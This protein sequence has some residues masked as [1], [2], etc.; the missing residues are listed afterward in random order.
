MSAPYTATKATCQQLRKNSIG[1]LLIVLACG[2]TVFRIVA[3]PCLFS[4]S[5]NCMEVAR[6]ELLVHGISCLIQ[7]INGYPLHACFHITGYVES[8]LLGNSTK[9]CCVK[10]TR[11]RVK[12]YGLRGRGVRTLDQLRVLELVVKAG[13]KRC[14][15][16]VADDWLACVRWYELKVF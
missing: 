8:G 13:L 3:N 5:G 9:W 1:I 12:S 4:L 6:S 7:R 15:F 2:S 11:N 10:C 14:A 16:C